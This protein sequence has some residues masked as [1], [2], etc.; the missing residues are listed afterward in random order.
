MVAGE[1][2]SPMMANVALLKLAPLGR[3]PKIRANNLTVDNY[4]FSRTAFVTRASLGFTAL[5]KTHGDARSTQIVGFTGS[6]LNQ[7]ARLLPIA[8]AESARTNLGLG[9]QNTFYQGA[10]RKILGAHS[11]NCVESAEKARGS[12]KGA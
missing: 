8:F 6:T 10:K 12:H 9:P 2:A 1:K 5:R 11:I 7:Q 4:N 3:K